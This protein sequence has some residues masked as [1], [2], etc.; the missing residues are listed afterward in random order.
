MQQCL[1]KTQFGSQVPNGSN[2]LKIQFLD[3]LLYRNR[4]TIMMKG[5][6]VHVEITPPAVA[7]LECPG[8]PC[9]L[10]VCLHRHP[11]KC[12]AIETQHISPLP[13]HG[14]RAH[15]V[16]QPPTNSIINKNA[17]Y[18][19]KPVEIQS[20]HCL[21]DSSELSNCCIFITFRQS[22][23]IIE[24]QIH[25]LFWSL[26]SKEQYIKNSCID[27]L[28]TQWIRP[29]SSVWI[30]QCHANNV[31]NRGLT[32]HEILIAHYGIFIF[33]TR[34]FFPTSMPASQCIGRVAPKWS[35]LMQRG[36]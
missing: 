34:R 31:Q 14:S 11:I 25:S 10:A 29:C 33:K 19:K 16:R 36:R 7:L 8:R 1:N 24:N 3:C 30:F 4:Q 13:F 21:N 15:F 5:W 17:W 28:N 32:F 26:M 23:I 27:L 9:L 20:T 35:Q 12:M 18:H 2:I 6:Y 22:N